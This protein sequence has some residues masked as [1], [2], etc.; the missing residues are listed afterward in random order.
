M[1]CEESVSQKHQVESG[2]RQQSSSRD[3]LGGRVW[4][5]GLTEFYSV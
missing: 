4:F 5:W 1:K 2:P 3:C